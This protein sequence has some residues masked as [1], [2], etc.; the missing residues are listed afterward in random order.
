MLCLPLGRADWLYLHSRRV[1]GLFA[2]RL[3]GSPKARELTDD[4]AGLAEA[5]GLRV[6]WVVEAVG[7]HGAFHSH[8]GVYVLVVAGGAPQR[9]H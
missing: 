6:R 2:F 3:Q 7:L 5:V 4:V 8:P 9:H 1:R